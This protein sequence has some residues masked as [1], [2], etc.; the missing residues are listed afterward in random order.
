MQDRGVLRERSRAPSTFAHELMTFELMASFELGACETG[1]RL[2]TWSEILQSKSLLDATRESAKPHQIPVTV[3][4]DG[5]VTATHVAADGEPFGIARSGSGQ[6]VYF[7][8]PGIE[9][10]C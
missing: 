8:C 4:I 2:I 5:A 6:R 10:D 3:T 1:A 7:F 9:A